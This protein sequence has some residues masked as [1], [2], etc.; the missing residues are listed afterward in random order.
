MLLVVL[1]ACILLATPFSVSAARAITITGNTT[2]LAGDQ[3]LTVTASPSGFV[4]GEPVYIKGAFFQNGTANYF[5]FTKFGD[6]WVKNSAANATQ[7]LITIGN[8]DNTI[9][10]KSD[11]GE[12]GYKGEGEYQFRLRFYYGASL[13]AD[14][15]IN[16]LTVLINEPDPTATPVPTSTS[17]PTAVPTIAP[18]STTTPTVLPT[19]TVSPTSTVTGTIIP[20]TTAFVLG[21]ASGAALRDEQ[22]A[23][24]P[25]SKATVAGTM[26]TARPLGIA[27]LFVS[28]GFALLSAMLVWH[29]IPIWRKRTV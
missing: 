17:T 15:S 21:D 13:T 16:T 8:W 26:Y 27:L 22:E 23:S 19:R 20:T 29:N 24:P 18:S 2:S 25:E 7:K 9:I 10:V 6:A 3:E 12:S 1:L 14:W 4:D 11:F 28:I 5:G